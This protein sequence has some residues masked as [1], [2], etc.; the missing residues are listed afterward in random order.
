MINKRYHCLTDKIFHFF[1]T[2]KKL[3]GKNSAMM[4]KCR[5]NQVTPDF[6]EDPG[7]RQT[8]QDPSCMS[9]H[10]AD[11][12]FFPDN[13]N[14][15]SWQR[16]KEWPFIAATGGE[17]GFCRAWTCCTWPKATSRSPTGTVWEQLRVV[18]GNHTRLISG[19]DCCWQS[20]RYELK[21]QTEGN[22]GPTHLASFTRSFAW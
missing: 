11:F 6:P 9:K 5:K 20:P 17:Q 8:F 7:S 13:C 16:F 14:S 22:I 4:K 18:R 10:T 3:L 12:G 2:S 15:R 19:H 1:T 21:E